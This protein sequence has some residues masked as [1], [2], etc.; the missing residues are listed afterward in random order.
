MTEAPTRHLLLVGA[1]HANIEVLRRFGRNP[2]AGTRITLLTPH[3]HAL[4]SGMLPGL[5]AGQYQPEDARIDAEALARAAGAGFLADRA[6]GLDPEKRLLLRTGGEPLAYD[7][8]ALDTGATPVIPDAPGVIPA[9]PPETLLACLEAA[10]RIAATTKPLRVAIVGGGPGGVEL[11]FALET[12]LRNWRAAA[13]ADPASLELT[14][15]PGSSGLLPGFPPG[16][17]RRVRRLCAA[18]GIALAPDSTAGEPVAG[19]LPLA[20]GTKIAADLS[21]WATPVTP[22]AWIAGTGLARDDAGFVAVDATLR[23]TSHETVFAAGDI[24]GFMPHALP[25]SGLHAVRQGTLL[26]KNLR[27]CLEGK[28][29]RAHRP[30]RAALYIL[31]TGRRHAIGTRN[32]LVFAGGWVRRWKDAIDRRFIGRYRAAESEPDPAIS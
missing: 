5:I 25:K 22:P 1:G 14:L 2:V 31:A 8:L 16:L 27:L 10:D 29:L 4:Y 20:D 3:R 21:I 30:Q 19:H 17:A 15:L 24:A 32:G 11:A 12:R 26:A 9:R 6:T 28:P 23:S 13:G 18:R 7:L